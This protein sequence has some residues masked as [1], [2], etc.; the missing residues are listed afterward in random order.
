[1][2]RRIPTAATKDSATAQA[3]VVCD[4][5]DRRLR[6]P[7]LSG[8]PGALWALT[9]SVSIAALTL[10]PAPAIA[11]QSLDGGSATG[12]NAYASG[13]DAV[14]TGADATAPASPMALTRP[15]PV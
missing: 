9:A 15:R 11:Q 13:G 14:A 7:V 2:L 3:S 10:A 12:S 6:G 8:L 1:M 5:R 4:P